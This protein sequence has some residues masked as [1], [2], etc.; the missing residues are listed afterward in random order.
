[1]TSS[2]APKISTGFSCLPVHGRRCA[3]SMV[4]LPAGSSRH[5]SKQGI[6]RFIGPRVT[7]C[8]PAIG[9][10][11][12]RRNPIT[13]LAFPL[14]Q[15]RLPTRTARLVAYTDRA[16]ARV[17]VVAALLILAAPTRALVQ[18]LPFRASTNLVR[19]DVVVLDREGK[20]VPNLTAEDFE[21]KQ[22]GAPQAIT[23]IAFVRPIGTAQAVMVR[24]NGADA[25]S[26]SPPSSPAGPP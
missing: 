16:V 5:R 1:M 23:A 11:P 18:T 19:V 10:I 2:S 15:R 25:S 22:D 20:A 12:T 24:P 17:L 8:S 6:S 4:A 21:L 13:T 3:R 26:G 9:S 14:S 7:F